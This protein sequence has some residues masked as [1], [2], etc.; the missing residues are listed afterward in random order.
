MTL[1]LVITCIFISL[2]SGHG[3]SLKHILTSSEKEEDRSCQTIQ[4]TTPTEVMQIQKV[5]LTL[6]V[7][8]KSNLDPLFINVVALVPRDKKFITRK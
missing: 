8:D 2:D 6:N 4:Q 5:R 7:I 3:I 1:K